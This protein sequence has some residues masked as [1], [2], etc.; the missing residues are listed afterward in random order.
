MKLNFQLYSNKP[1][2]SI[3]VNLIKIPQHIIGIDMNILQKKI[4]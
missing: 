2:E 1:N 4:M 3:K